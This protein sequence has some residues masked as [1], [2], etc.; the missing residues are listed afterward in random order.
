[1][2]E[3]QH[4]DK[5]N[6]FFDLEEVDEAD[7][8]MRI[9][10]QSLTGDVNKWFKALVAG[11]LNN[12]TSFHQSFLSIWK[13]KKNALQILSEY[14]SIKRNQGESVQDYCAHFNNIYNA[15]QN[16][17]KPPQILYLIKVP[18]GFDADI[19]YQLRDINPAT[20]EEMKKCVVTV[21]ENMLAKTD[22]QGT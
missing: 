21:E 5:M 1:M 13:L 16:N 18:D 12:I 19:S 4:V 17:I 15:I 6:D 3:K 8:Q 9:F 7:V 10:S 11:I 20:L 2:N 14:E 22:R